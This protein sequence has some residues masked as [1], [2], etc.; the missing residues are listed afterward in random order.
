M[1]AGGRAAV[2]FPCYFDSAGEHALELRLTPDALELDNRRYLAVPV[3]DQVRVLCVDGRPSGGRFKSAT[4]F[5][6]VALSP[7]VDDRQRSR[8]HPEVVAESALLETDLTQYEC[9]FLCNVA[10]FTEREAA[11]LLS[12][13]NFGGGLVFFL[14]DQV[15]PENYN[16]LLAAKTDKEKH[17]L[18]ARLGSPVEAGEYGLDPLGYRH[19]LVAAFRDAEQAGLLTT[20]LQTYF[21]LQLNQPTQAKVALATS[22]GD[23]LLVEETIL[24][25]R[26]ILVA[27][28]ADISWTAM[29]MWP[30]YVPLVQEMLLFAAGGRLE[31]HNLLVGQPLGGMLPQG[32]HR[33]PR[34]ICPRAKPSVP[35]SAMMVPTGPGLTSIPGKAVFIASRPPITRTLPP[36]NKPLPSI[37]TPR[38]AIWNKSRPKNWPAKCGRACGI[39]TVRIGATRMRARPKRS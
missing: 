37:S 6:T 31:E 17:V 39:F 9:V 3:K 20:P 4:D 30:S 15:R 18:P 22:N 27:T 29:P 33:A 12:Y 14:G 36:R 8:V 2:S 28:S 13:L 19:P 25:G 24:R 35:P 38:R 5:L 26:S 11:V 16:R 7:T 10:Q 34:C 23:P 21:Q 32:A 1:A